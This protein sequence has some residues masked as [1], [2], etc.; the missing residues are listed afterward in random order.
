MKEVLVWSNPLIFRNQL[1]DLIGKVTNLFIDEVNL[2]ARISARFRSF[3]AQAV[4]RSFIFTALPAI[5]ALPSPSALP[6][7]ARLPAV[8]A[9]PAVLALPRLSADT[10]RVVLH[11]PALTSR[12]RLTAW[13][14]TSPNR[15]VPDSAYEQRELRPE[16]SFIPARRLEDSD[17][18]TIA[19]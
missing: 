19:E 4:G 13:S 17:E 11:F 16:S 18:S 12:V 1:L 6:A 5:T 3:A 8:P 15:R 14:P 9:R 2:F 7:P 10:P